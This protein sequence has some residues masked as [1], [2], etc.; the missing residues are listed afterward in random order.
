MTGRLGG[1][2]ALI[3][4]GA[5][6]MGA[7][8]ARA[9]VAAGG[10]VTIA[11]V[12]AEQGEALAAE[13][14]A[15]R[16]QF[17]RLDVTDED[18]W[19]DAVEATVT[20][21]GGLDVLVNN[22]GILDFGPLAT[23]PTQRWERVLRVNL[24]GAFLGMKAAAGALTASGTGSII[25][26]SSVAGRKGIAGVSAYVASKHALIGLTKTAALELA[27]AGIRVNAVLPGNIATD[28]LGGLD[29]FPS[30]PMHRPARP[31]EVSTLVVFLASEE[32]SFITGADY[33]VDGG[34]IAG[35]APDPAI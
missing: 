33:L 19:A 20:R 29:E 18:Q 25:N 13:L 9:V 10:R 2:V 17:V 15:E 4:G 7:S 22:A 35:N 8:H 3:T 34:E 5:A 11:D 24:T 16:A 31:E 14:G 27:G 6:G 1:R 26:V 28:M 21:F 12:N 32:S 30:V 23:F